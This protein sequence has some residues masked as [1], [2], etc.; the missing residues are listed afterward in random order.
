MEEINF[1]LGPTN[2][3]GRVFELGGYGYPAGDMPA[4]SLSKFQERAQVLYQ[5]LQKVSNMISTAL[6]K[7]FVVPPL[8]GL[9]ESSYQLPANPSHETS[10]RTAESQK[11]LAGNLVY[12][13]GNVGKISKWL[14]EVVDIGVE[15]S[16][17]G[18]PTVQLRNPSTGINFVNEGFGSNQLLFV[19]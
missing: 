19:L 12:W 4:T 2:H 7:F 8:R 15:T 11:S 18:G 16:I 17:S 3:I 5:A 6:Q 10:W 13:S 1:G 14:S 9:T